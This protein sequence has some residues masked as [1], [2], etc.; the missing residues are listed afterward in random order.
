MPRQRRTGAVYPIKTEQRKKLT[1]GTVK[2]YVRYRAKVGGKWISAKTYRECS[3]KIADALKEQTTWGAVSDKTAKLGDYMDEWLEAKSHVV[4]PGTFD[5]YRAAVRVHLA[6]YR[7]TRLADVTPT[8]AR[9]MLN[10]MRNSRDGSK[11]ATERLR[12]IHNTMRQIFESAVADRIIPTNPMVAVPTPRDRDLRLGERNGTHSQNRTAFTVEQMRAMLETSSRD[13]ITGAREW[14]RLLTGMRQGEVLGVILDDLELHEVTMPDGSRAWSGYY[15]CNWK[16]EQLRKSHG[17]GDP[18]RDGVYPC[19]YKNA[20]RCPHAEWRE[21][22]GF[23]KIPVQGRLCLTPPK[24]HRGKVIPIITAL[25]TVI[26]RYIEATKDVPNP[27]GLLFRN[28]DGSPIDPA[29]D[30]AGFRRMLEEA[31]IPDP[32]HRY[33]HECRNSVV[34]LLFSMGVD[35]GIIQRIVGHSSLEMSEHYRTVPVEEL[36]E[37]MEAIDAGLDLKQIEWKTTIFP[38]SKQY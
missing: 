34:S 31:G 28:R 22:D 6:P 25:G 26:H 4:D 20:A 35:P 29:V 2:T 1:D 37:G 15:T 19:G 24:S 36:M 8:V 32:Q 13:L 27:H 3:R 9:H 5:S 7:K 30:R 14:W 17:C 18:D 12:T 33:V 11:L 21:P 10:N 23:D 38:L 16:L